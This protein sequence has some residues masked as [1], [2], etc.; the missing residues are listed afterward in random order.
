MQ[1]GFTPSWA[2]KQFYMINARS[3]GDHNA[4]NH[5][6]YRGAMGILQKPMFRQSIRTRRCL[7]IADA[8]IEG[9]QTRKARQTL[10]GLCPG[11]PA[12]L[13]PRRNLGRVGRLHRIW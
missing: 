9:P 7:V 13:C 12:A 2:K 8:F 6:G 4:D 1:F 3:E 10:C 5:P 11:R